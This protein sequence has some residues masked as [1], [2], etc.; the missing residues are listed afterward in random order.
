MENILTP[1]TIDHWVQIVYD[2]LFGNLFVANTLWQLATV[3]VAFLLAYM[4]AGP[5]HRWIDGQRERRPDASSIF[6]HITR[7]TGLLT[8]PLYWLLFQWGAVLGA[9]YANWPNHLIVVV[10]SLLS[11]WVV[12]RFTSILVRD[13][14][15]SKPIAIVAWSIAAL[16]IVGLLNP[17]IEILDSLAVTLGDVRISALTVLKGVLAL[18]ILLWIA[19]VLSQFLERR[20]RSVPNLTPSIQE[21]FAKLFKVVFITIAFIVALDIVGIDLTAFALF[22]GA[23]GVGIGFGLQKIVANLISGIILL[24]DKSVKPGDVIEIG[25]EIGWINSLGARY[26]SV[27]THDGVEHL[28]PNEILISERVSNWSYSNQKMRLKLPV[29]ISYSCDPRQARDLCIEAA[30]ECERVLESPPPNCLLKGFGDNS[31]DLDVS[32]W[33]NDPKKGV[34]NVKSDVLFRIWDKFKAADIEIPFPQRDL[35]I[36]SPTLAAAFGKNQATES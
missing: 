33:I 24:L 22:G 36:K 34:A 18:A 1:E 25:G 31:V 4:A 17:L 30:A 28:I 26:V 16:N 10:V 7:A 21:L 20:I 9:G 29:G 6:A 23:V 3:V 32:F 5:T 19:G 11:A 35:H 27:V 12:I 8:L 13:P 14:T 15:W 2:W